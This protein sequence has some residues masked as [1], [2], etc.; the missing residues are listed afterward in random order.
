M[1]AERPLQ[2]EFIVAI[3]SIIL[4]MSLYSEMLFLL[5]HQ[6]VLTIVYFA[7]I[8][9]IVIAY[10]MRFKAGSLSGSPEAITDAVFRD[11]I[12]SG[13]ITENAGDRIRVRLSRSVGAR[14][15]L[16]RT[17]QKWTVSYGIELNPRGAFWIIPL[18][19][20]VPFVSFALM[21]FL[22]G[23]VNR[24]GKGE[25][26][27]I[28]SRVTL[29][30]ENRERDIKGLL[31]ESL[32]EARRISFEAHE[33]LK[34]DYED[35]QALS[36]VAGILALS[37]TI[38]FGAWGHLDDPVSALI[39]FSASFSITT[40]LSMLLARRRFKPQLDKVRAWKDLLSFALN[41]EIF[42]ASDDVSPDSSFEMLARATKEMPNWLE[43]RRKGMLAREPVWSMSVFIMIFLGFFVTLGGV[44]R[45]GSDISQGL[46]AIILGA[47]LFAGG[48]VI[49]LLSERRRADE[50]SVLKEKWGQRSREIDT[51]MEQLFG[52]CQ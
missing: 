38:M 15:Q 28:L 46:V 14:I 25:L 24:F 5:D 6:T 51:R 37:A 36:L 1:K 11:L 27:E 50:A 41:V 34:S 8:A 23:K 39:A 29:D 32:S 52:G 18:G 40:A 2:W 7:P 13:A 4:L 21:L 45:V 44:L 31:V 30:P 12:A 22:L 9:G 33:V 35:L 10:L 48:M 43:I 17:D 47:V 42:P 20:I 49:Y 19:L 16:S 26:R 3:V